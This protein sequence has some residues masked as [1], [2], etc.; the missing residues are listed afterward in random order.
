MINKITE[1]KLSPIPTRF[2]VET[3]DLNQV[4]RDEKEKIKQLLTYLNSLKS[5][6]YVLLSLILMV[7][8]LATGIQ[9]FITLVISNILIS[10]IVFSSIDSVLIIIIIFVWTIFQNQIVVICQENEFDF[11]EL[12]NRFEEN[13]KFDAR[14]I[15]KIFHEIDNNREIQNAESKK[16]DERLKKP[17]I[18]LENNTQE[19]NSNANAGVEFGINESQNISKISKKEDVFL[20][21]EENSFSCVQL[22]KKNEFEKFKVITIR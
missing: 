8:V 12:K 5:K 13:D 19:N 3:D 22:G 16:I 2:Y 14:T 20:T 21:T 1:I 15:L 4:P 10:V 18:I 6:N 7:L 11:K 17:F 9:V